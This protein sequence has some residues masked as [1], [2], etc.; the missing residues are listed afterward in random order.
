MRN[1]LSL[2]SLGDETCWIL[3]KQALGIP[4]AKM[5]SDFMVGRV[6]LLLFTRQS[7]PER[8]CVTAAVRQ[9][10]GSTIYQ[11]ESGGVWRAEISD[12]QEQL[13]AIFGYYVDCVYLYGFKAADIMEKN[14]AFRF[15]IINAG[16]P[17]SHPAHALADIACML[18]AIKELKGIKTTWVGCGN[19]TLFSMMEATKWF[20]FSLTVSMPPQVDSEP[21]RAKAKEMG[22]EINF[23]DNPLE[24]VKN[25]AFVY[26][27][28]RGG[29]SY[30]ELG[31]WG[32]T[33]GLMK[34]A[35][36]DARVLLSASPIRA[37]HISPDV[38]RKISAMLVRQ[39]EY[40]LRIHKRLLHWVFA[41][42]D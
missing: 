31:E 8:L 6:A 19:G 27:G 39:A 40:R 13:L 4:D 26:A 5:L 1:V 17:D 33:E 38:M 29:L 35:S 10:S 16:S 15:A 22:T 42:T 12:F 7:L 25:S 21:F 20:N 41:R 14:V 2:A 30:E 37:I 36:P 11:G 23:V 28:A 32:I 3:V 9:M 34:A 24:A 18:R